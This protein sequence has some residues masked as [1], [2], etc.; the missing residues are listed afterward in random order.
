MPTAAQKQNPNVIAI[1][2]EDRIESV[3][4]NNPV[5]LLN[6]GSEDQLN[7]VDGYITQSAMYQFGEGE[8]EQLL[9]ESG[10]EDEIV[11]QTGVYENYRIQW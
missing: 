2:S 9:T 10:L 6:C 11:Y 4:K 7:S 1:K 3:R 8:W 5:I